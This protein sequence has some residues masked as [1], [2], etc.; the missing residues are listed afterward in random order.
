[1][2]ALPGSIPNSL[3][4]RNSVV[5]EICSCA[6]A[7]FAQ[8][9]GNFGPWNYIAPDGTATQVVP[10]PATLALLAGAGLLVGRRR[11]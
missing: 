11:R 3:S 9:N 8:T 2:P 4:L 5:V 6:A 1:M 10:E 7:R